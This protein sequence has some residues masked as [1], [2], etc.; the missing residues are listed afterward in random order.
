[1]NKLIPALVKAKSFFEKAGNQLALADT[2]LQVA[3]VLLRQ[4]KP[5]QAFQLAQTCEP[6]F[7]NQALPVGQARACLVA[8]Q[9]AIQANLL[10]EAEELISRALFIGQAHELPALTYQGHHLQGLLAVSQNN[11]EG[12]LGC[13]PKINR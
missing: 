10:I 13:L 12:R 1:M 8:A 6:I 11:P 7:E 5:E 3:A 4:N 9:A 2:D